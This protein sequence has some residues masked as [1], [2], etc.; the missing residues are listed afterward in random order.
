MNENRVRQTVQPPVSS[1]EEAELHLKM[2]NLEQ[3]KMI[4]EALSEIGPFGEIRLIKA[5]GKLRFIQTLD[6]RSAL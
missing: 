4:D 6:S 1:P 5:K 3:V 2:L